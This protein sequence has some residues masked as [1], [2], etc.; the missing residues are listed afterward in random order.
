MTSR[1]LLLLGSLVLFGSACS[2]PTVPEVGS[3]SHWLAECSVG[4]DCG[5]GLSCVCGACT[6]MC[7]VDATCAGDVPAACYDLSSPALVQR[8]EGSEGQP[9]SGVCLRECVEASECAANKA[10]IEGACVPRLASDPVVQP[11]GGMSDGGGALSRAELDELLSMDTSVDVS[12]PLSPPTLVSGVRGGD[13]TITGTWVEESCDP[14][15]ASADRPWGCVRLTLARDAA[16]KVTG[17]LQTER[18]AVPEGFSDPAGPYPPAEDPDVGYP[19]GAAPE[20]YGSHAY[21]FPPGI[22]YRVLDGRF[23]VG[24][25]TFAWSPFD[26]WNDWCEL[27][28]SYP[29]T[30]GERA[31]AFC[32][33][34]DKALWTEIDE[35]KI[36][37]CTTVDLEPFCSGGG[38]GVLPCACIGDGNLP[39]CSSAYCQCDDE[40]CRAD[41]GQL[42]TRVELV[43]EGETMT[44]SWR[45]RYRD[46]RGT[47]RR[48]S[49]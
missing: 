27:Q 30:V 25:L 21:G 8:C 2:K 41:V 47:L 48:V 9:S 43:V 42:L 17:T 40:G 34:Q 44:G 13:E 1:R 3:E 35:G 16:G 20:T 10:C 46:W 28:T 49:P 14:A 18:T 7:S 32:V 45:H 33:P 11:D 38:D 15:G 24:R 5:D 19:L 4:E 22:P 6:R 12:T 26:L 23:E 29:W 39:R 31:F 37:L 36:V